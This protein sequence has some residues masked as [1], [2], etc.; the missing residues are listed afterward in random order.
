[1]TQEEYDEYIKN[2]S[3][4]GATKNKKPL[5][6]FYSIN[7]ALIKFFGN[8]DVQ[9]QQWLGSASLDEENCADILSLLTESKPQLAQLKFE[10]SQLKLD[11]YAESQRDKIEKQIR[12]IK[13]EMLLDEVEL[14]FSKFKKFTKL[15]NKTSESYK[16]NEFKKEKNIF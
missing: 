7:G 12:Y 13:S 16:K 15:Y 2:T 4:L 1:M 3:G 8:I 6:D 5:Q 9:M 14:V 11:D 10:V